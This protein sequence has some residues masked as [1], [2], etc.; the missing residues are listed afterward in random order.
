MNPASID[1]K[2]PTLVFDTE[3]YVD[4]WLIA[5]RHVTTGQVRTFEKFEGQDL[6]RDAVLRL[7]KAYRVV[8][9]NSADYDV[10]MITAALAGFSCPQL[11]QLSDHIILTSNEG[12][13][14]KPWDVERS[15]NLVMPRELD[16]I[17]LIEVAFG[18]GSLKLYG[19]RLHSQRLQD[20]PINPDA[21][22]SP[23]DRAVL[24][25]YCANDL[26]TT[27]DLF[28]ALQADLALRE[29]ISVEYGVDV[30]SKS[31]A[32]VAEAIIRKRVETALGEKV[33]RPEIPP[34]STFR[35]QPPPF[36]V[37]SGQPC[38][39][40]FEKV[41]AAE[42]CIKP[43]GRP[44]VP[45]WGE[46]TDEKRAEGAP[47]VL[48]GEGIYRMGY[49]GL[50]SSEQC[51]SYVSND[52]EKLFDNDVASYYPRIIE[53]LAL[54]PQHIGPVY[55]GIYSEIIKTRLAAKAS[56]DKAT[57]QTLKIVLNGSFGKYG[58]RWSVLYAPNLMIQVTLTGQLCLLMLIE[59]FERFGIPVISAN[60]DGVICRCPVELI[61]T[62]NRILK[63]WAEATGFETEETPYKA[64]YSRDVNNYLALKYAFDEKSKTWL[65][66]PGGFKGK[67]AF[68][69]GTTI[70]AILA[71]NPAGVIAID[72]VRAFLEHG[73][74]INRTIYGCKDVRKFLFVRRVQGGGAY[75]GQYL[76]KVVRWYIG[77][78]RN[79]PIRYVKSGNKV[80]RTD[81]CVP[82]MQLPDS[83]PNDIDFSWYAKEAL[84]ILK[85]IG[86]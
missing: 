22:I 40:A 52:R 25:D 42:F 64:V 45:A 53:E 62:K 2:R 50:H 16:H 1:P 3:C 59:A 38:R 65:D 44:W 61:E 35:Y 7:M 31:D 41:K 58:S 12:R 71:K 32:Q 13:P 63:Q 23:S 66:A 9:F 81:G 28:N 85:D 14:I 30:R 34:G 68:N 67:G 56:G 80:A 74:P 79:E 48:I 11:K 8:G 10:P 51:A 54:F 83:L 19:G 6:D 76:G 29:R 47:E 78:A 77:V 70:E 33:Y 86:A 69:D 4:Y 55:L 72:A 75:A 43:N 82:C 46:E 24:R 49:G 27:L 84:N 57:A 5:F 39:E 17:D 21:L 15:H 26:S 36:I 18:D 37:F 20:L 60:T 73:V